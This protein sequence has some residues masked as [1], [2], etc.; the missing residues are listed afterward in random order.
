MAVRIV[1]VWKFDFLPV[2]RNKS[3]KRYYTTEPKLC[4]LTVFSSNQRQF[5]V[6]VVQFLCLYI[7]GSTSRI[8]TFTL[9]LCSFEKTVT[10]MMLPP[11]LWSGA[12]ALKRLLMPHFKT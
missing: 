3:N 6:D 12:L 2:C 11:L 5:F 4:L 8:F 10:D 1:H 9:H 7:V